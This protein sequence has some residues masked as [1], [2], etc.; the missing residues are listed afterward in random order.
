MLARGAALLAMLPIAC[1]AVSCDGSPAG[2]TTRP[3][4]A[5]SAGS[6]SSV[7]GSSGGGG[8]S[9]TID[10]CSACARVDETGSVLNGEITEASGIAASASF[11]DVFYLHNDSGDVPRFFATD[12]AGA[13][14]GVFNVVNAVALDWED[15]ARGPCP[16]GSCLFLAD[17]GDNAEERTTLTIYRVPEPSAIRQGAHDV[18]AEPLPFHYPDGSHNAEAVVVHPVSGVITLITKVSS[19]A[20]AIYELPMPLTIREEAILVKK[21][22]VTP[23]SGSA[24]ITAADLHPQGLGLLVRTYTH[25]FYYAGT[26]GQSAAEMLA[27]TPCSVPVALEMQGEAVAWLRSGAGYLTVSEGGSPALNG[28]ACTR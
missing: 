22:E 9:A 20:S 12:A 15:M 17:I 1:A 14:L 24:R 18:T 26:P 10:F 4:N 5:A 8:S 23:P 21:G 25:V 28:A 27:G 2:P 7:S 19:G 16:A 6:G 3:T 11:A 13:D